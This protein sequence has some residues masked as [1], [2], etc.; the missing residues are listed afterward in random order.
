MLYC[1]ENIQ[2]QKCRHAQTLSSKSRQT[3]YRHAN[4]RHTKLSLPSSRIMHATATRLT[5]KTTRSQIHTQRD[6]HTD[7]HTNLI[8][9]FSQIIH[10]ANSRL[11]PTN[12]QT[13][14]AH[15]HTDRH[16]NLP[17]PSSQIIH[18]ATT[19]LTQKTLEARCTRTHRQTH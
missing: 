15:I 2:K 7:R 18:T 5:Q 12:Y 14:V 13:P 9:P 11:T 6:R 17:L 16:S 19:R 8:L 3:I 4:C 10:A 1:V